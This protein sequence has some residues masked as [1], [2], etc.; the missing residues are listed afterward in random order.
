M[1]LFTTAV[2]FAS[3]S[4]AAIARETVEDAARLARELVASTGIGTLA[5]VFADDH[6]TLGGQSLALMEYYSASCYQNGSLA[7]VFLPISQNSRNILKSPTKA[8]T[9]T[10]SSTPAAAANARVALVGSV[11]VTQ[12][13]D[14]TTSEA[15]EKCYTQAHPDSAAWLP[16]KPDAPH[17]AY[18]ARFDPHSVYYVGGFGDVHYIGYI[19]LDLYAASVPEARAE[20]VIG[21]RLR[22]QA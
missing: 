10:V 4:A 19:P 6:P 16:G 13:L 12:S 8:A 20:R 21:G 11:T 2:L 5:T 17:R 7:L 18:W 14:R 1:K 3:V 22:V 15:L 9:V